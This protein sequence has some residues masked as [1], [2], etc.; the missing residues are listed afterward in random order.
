VPITTGTTRQDRVVVIAGLTGGE[1]L[2]LNPPDGLQD[3]DR[4][5]P[6]R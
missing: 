4:V 3:G 2:V 6:R 5:S 1:T